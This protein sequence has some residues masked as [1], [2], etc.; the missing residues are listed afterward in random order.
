MKIA[1]AQSNADPIAAGPESDLNLNPTRIPDVVV[2]E[3]KLIGDDRGF[4]MECWHAERFR[5]AGID[6]TFVQDNHSRSTHG[7]LRGLH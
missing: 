1:W 3:P 6:A 4:F 5:R 2:V 7:V